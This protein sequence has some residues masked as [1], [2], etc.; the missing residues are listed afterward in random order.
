MENKNKYLER[1]VSWMYFNQRLIQEAQDKTVPLLNRIN[2][3]GIY[4]NNLDEFF[5][6]RVAL[7]NRIMK[8]S[9]SSY[10][11]EKNI[12]KKTLSKLTRLNKQYNDQYEIA[13]EEIKKELEILNIFILNEKQISDDHKREIHDLFYS[14]LNPY[15]LPRMISQNSTFDDLSDENVFL[16]VKL[17][18]SQ[19]NCEYALIELR[20]KHLGRFI[21]LSSDNPDRDDFLFLDD[22]TRV[23]LPLIFVGKKYES[24]EAYTF[25]ITKDA[26]IDVE[27]NLFG[28]FLI[29]LAQAVKNRKKGHPVRFIYD[30][31]MPDDLLAKLLKIF[32]AG[33][34]DNI[35]VGSRY[36]N[37]KDLMSFPDIN[38]KGLK[39]P[40]DKPI[41]VK[42]LIKPISSFDT[43]VKKD[44]ILHY[45]YY[46]FYNYVRVIQEAAIS[47]DVQSIKITLYRLARNSSVANALISAARNGKKVTAVIELFARFDEESNIYWSS[48]M[49]E[50]GINVIHGIEGLKIHS[51]ITLIK[52][53]KDSI[54][55]ISTGNFH[56]GNAAVYTDITLMTANQKLIKEADAVFDFFEKPYK[57]PVFKELLVSPINLRKGIKILINNEINNAKRGKPA[58]IMGKIN[59]IVDNDI[60]DKL[61]EAAEAGVKIDLLVR[62][63]CSLITTGSKLKDNITI[64]GIIDKYLEHSRVLIFCNNLNEKYYMGSADWITRNFDARVEVM[65]PVYDKD[66]R[67]ELKIIVEYG[68]RD[69]RKAR[70]VDGTGSNRIKKSG[71]PFRS[72]E[73]LYEHYL[74]KES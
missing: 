44:V 1:E 60:A 3:L 53:K 57:I 73:K 51:K 4:S 45:P 26:E 74:N 29:K 20:T 70:I 68:L 37:M 6:I 69:N 22:I 66:I 56:E 47:K 25:K 24:Y 64:K 15:L 61:Y 59:H 9:D 55:C 54:V 49:R 32:K 63:N 50:A 40:K 58:Y 62:G 72:Q 71:K 48:K 11:M 34:A 14:K 27:P 10:K 13:F 41:L 46:S 30:E 8:L 28:D 17:G 39:Y 33:K 42:N 12:T 67:K 19:D 65:T 23:C 21:Q 16:A 7:L 31:A 43:I 2:F 5:R 52:R 35:V 38:I 36:H 18:V